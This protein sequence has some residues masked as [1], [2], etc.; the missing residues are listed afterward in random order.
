VAGPSTAAAAR[1]QRS[2]TTRRAL[3]DAAIAA[4][5]E[6]GYGGTTTLEVQARAGVSRGAL[7][8]HFASRAD[9]IL[10]AVDH[11]SRERLDEV[12]RLART[13]APAG[14]RLEWAV[15][16]MWATFDGPLFKAAL[17]LW[18]AARGDP[19]LLAALL[20]QERMLG[21]AIR[22]MAAELFGPVHSQMPAFDDVLEVLLDA[23]RGAA[24]R[25]VLRTPESEKRLVRRWVDYVS[26]RVGP[27]A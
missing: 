2:A 7:L 27:G 23:M 21:Q 1:S 15:R 4:L 10:A 19:E 6:K 9:L 18:L 13:E 26:T 16:T 5:E 20:P 8:H 3:L 17:E 14:D 25:G 11:L 24:A 22:G 12:A